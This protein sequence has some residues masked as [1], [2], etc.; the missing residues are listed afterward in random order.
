MNRKRILICLKNKLPMDINGNNKFFQLDAFPS[1]LS[2][3]YADGK[4][5]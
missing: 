4:P 1:E 5:K 3:D 2:N